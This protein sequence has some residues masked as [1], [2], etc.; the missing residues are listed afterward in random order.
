M[1]KPSN[2]LG[3]G[4]R[5][6]G[7]VCTPPLRQGRSGGVVVIMLGVLAEQGPRSGGEVCKICQPSTDCGLS[8]P[9]KSAV[10]AN[11]LPFGSRGKTKK[12]RVSFSIPAITINYFGRFI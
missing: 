6:A 3:E 5:R 9:E 11:R 8:E 7:E 10:D 12:S 2:K 4:A 1:G